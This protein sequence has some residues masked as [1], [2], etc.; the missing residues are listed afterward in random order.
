MFGFTRFFSR[1]PTASARSFHR[2][3]FTAPVVAHKGRTLVAALVGTIAV[4]GCVYYSTKAT[5]AEPKP[6]LD[7]NEWRDFKLIEKS[8]VSPNAS[9][10]RFALDP[11]QDL[12][13]PVSSFILVQED[14][15]EEK[16]VVRPYTPVTYD[17]KG[18]FDLLIK[19]YPT[20]K[21]SKHID[22]LKIGQSIH[23]KGP[24]KKIP[25]TPN[26]KKSIGMIAGGS[27]I[28]PMLQ[29]IR[30]ILNNP[31]DKTEIS[32][33]Y[34]NTTEQD[35]LVGDYLYQLAEEYPNFHIYYTVSKPPPGWTQGVGH[36][37]NA[38]IKSKLP[39]PSND[40]IIFVCGPPGMVENVCGPKVEYEQGPLLGLLKDLGYTES[41]VFKF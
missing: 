23:V 19:T 34:S 12:G 35:I 26:M 4:A 27:G 13:L 21:Y 16:P 18:H 24:N 17:E 10:Y 30:H 25:I 39:A 9:L 2:N 33:L 22:S 32:L 5:A 40:S 36:V 3:F 20:G 28:T 31:E 38:M 6:A 41:Q 29:I 1:A 14:L 11:D 7:P 8:K 15:G 37:T